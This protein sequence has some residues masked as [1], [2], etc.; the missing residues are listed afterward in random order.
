MSLRLE[1]DLREQSGCRDILISRIMSY[2]ISQPDRKNVKMFRKKVE[3]F[4]DSC[5]IINCVLPFS[6]L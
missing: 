3:Y 4:T 6:Y 1:E 5:Y 2:F